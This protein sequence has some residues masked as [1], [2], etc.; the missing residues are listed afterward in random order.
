[1]AASASSI[2]ILKDSYKEWSGHNATRLA[3]AIAFY[4]MMSLAPL[5]VVA[6]TITSFVYRGKGEAQDKIGKQAV[7]FVGESGGQAV[8][9][10]ISTSAAHAK[11]GL[12]WGIISFVVAAVSASSLFA[13][14]QDSLNTMWD[15]KPKPDA[16]WR[17]MVRDRLM[18]MGVLFGAGV[19]LIA[20]FVASAILTFL[21]KHASGWWLVALSNAADF[22]VTLALMTA[23]FGLVFKFLPDVKIQWS[24]VW[25]GAAF[26]AMLF[27]LGK[28]ALGLYF[29]YASVTSPFGAFGSLAALLIW[30]N[31]SA[32]L[33][34]FGAAITRAYA[35]A[36]GH[37]LEP[38]EFAMRMTHD[39]RVQKGLAKPEEV[40]QKQREQELAEAR[41]RPVVATC[42]GQSKSG[43]LIAAGAGLAVGILGTLGFGNT[44]ER[45]VRREA[46]AMRLHGRVKRL[47]RRA[48]GASRLHDQLERMDIAHRVHRLQ[49]RIE[50]A[51]HEAARRAARS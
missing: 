20:A 11:G 5:L 21:L 14:L 42:N 10:M 35:R 26:T 49:D 22:I 41:R 23:I 33:L 45:R 27:I 37:Q 44:L 48:G 51:A 28:Y 38:N 6:L 31:Y 36:S 1:M 40:I 19:L 8:Q 9:Q 34:F 50:W 13:S 29:R 4:T 7:A 3:A 16:G 24:D 17:A 43:A 46:Q 30:V 25:L 12:I 2:A 15:V 39:D 18:A 47:E 32:M